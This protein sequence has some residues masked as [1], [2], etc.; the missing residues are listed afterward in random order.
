MFKLRRISDNPILA[1]VAEHEWEREAVFNCGAVHYDGLFHMV[2]RASDRPFGDFTKKFVTRFG[3]AV[4]RDGVNFMRQ[5]NPVFEDDDPWAEWGVEDPRIVR[6]DNRFYVTYSTWDGK[7][8]HV[9]ARLAT[10]ED[11]MVW[12]RH[13][14]LLDETNKNAALFPEK[15]GGRYALL[16]RREPDIW[17]CFSADLKKWAEHR[18]IMRPRPG[19]WD[20]VKIGIA[21]PPVRHPE[22]W[23]LVYHGV[24]ERK[25]YRLGAALLD[26]ENPTKVLGRQDEPI[27]EP[28]LDWETKGQVPNVVFSCATVDGGDSYYVYYGA[29]DTVIGVAAVEKAKVRFE[30]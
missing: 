30:T 18:R 15:T 14:L 20:G 4:S 26:A 6:L 12:Q 13:G 19:K 16:H 2:Y 21:G 27:L 9:R 1:P 17:V 8:E 11:F 3:Y 28:E 7:A 25:V 22:G 29:A 24:D 10:T 23:L 5:P